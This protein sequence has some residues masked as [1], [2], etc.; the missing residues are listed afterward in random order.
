MVVGGVRVLV[1]VCRLVNGALVLVCE[2]EELRIGTVAVGVS[3]PLGGEGKATAWVF[4]TRIQWGARALAE[5]V[6]QRM[7][8]VA[9]VSLFLSR[10]GESRVVEILGA[11]RQV[12]SR[13]GVVG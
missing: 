7:G 10:Q 5:L 12:L 9:I 2:G 1:A 13:M 4:G 11:V 8:G 6:A 3:S